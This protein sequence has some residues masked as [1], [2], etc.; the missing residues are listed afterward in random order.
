MKNCKK[1]GA[2]CIS[3]CCPEG[4]E[5][6][7]GLCEYIKIVDNKTILCKK[8]VDKNYLNITIDEGC[9]LQEYP[10]VYEIYIKKR[11][12]FIKSNNVY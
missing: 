5:N 7:F 2:C 4:I 3:G 10:D 9:I 11:D 6:E 12:E 8:V 1:C